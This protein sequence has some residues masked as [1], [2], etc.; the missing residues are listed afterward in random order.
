MDWLS[1]GEFRAVLVH[2]SDGLRAQTLW[3]ADQF[4]FDDRLALPKTV[5]PLQLARN[6]VVTARLSQIAF[7]DGEHFSTLVDAILPLARSLEVSDF[8]VAA[9]HEKEPEVFIEHPSLC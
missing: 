5:R 3:Y 8:T 4:V 2:S 1:N 9:F 7:H 6:P